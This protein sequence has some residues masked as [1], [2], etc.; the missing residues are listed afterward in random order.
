MVL[1]LGQMMEARTGSRMWAVKGT[2][3]MLEQHTRGQSQASHGARVDR[4]LRSPAWMITKL[5]RLVPASV[6]DIA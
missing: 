1:G 5:D 6:P 2:S 3:W 4:Q